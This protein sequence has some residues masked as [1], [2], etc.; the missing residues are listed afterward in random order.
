MFNTPILSTGEPST[1]KVWRKLCAATFGED[2]KSVKFLDDK[3][4]SSPNGEDEPVLASE[5]QLLQALAAIH[6]QGEQ[7]KTVKGESDA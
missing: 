1:L 4:A 2:S 5:V 3:I 7:E 6:K